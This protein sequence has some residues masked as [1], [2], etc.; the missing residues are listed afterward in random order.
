MKVIAPLVTREKISPLV[1]NNI[2]N[3]PLAGV[4]NIAYFL[5]NALKMKKFAALSS[6]IFLI[7]LSSCIAIGAI[8]K[9]GVWAGVSLI[10]GILALVIFLITRGANK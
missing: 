10:I 2:I 8:F 9:A 3:R 4:L 5:L 1:T 7:L 6:V